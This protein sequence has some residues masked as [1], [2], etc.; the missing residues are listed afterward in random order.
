MQ[1]GARLR[2]QPLGPRGYKSSATVVLQPFLGYGDRYADTRIGAI[3]TRI[4]MGEEDNTFGRAI[5]NARLGDGSA[6]DA[7]PPP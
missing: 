3:V 1:G 2:A 4:R 5:G 6:S 7:L